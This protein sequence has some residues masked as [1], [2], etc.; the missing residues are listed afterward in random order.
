VILTRVQH[1]YGRPSL[2]R[3][4][5]SLPIGAEV[6]VDGPAENPNPWRGYR[7]CL[8]NL[9]DASH[10][11]VVQDDTVAC[12][13]LDL[14]LPMLAEARPDTLTSLFVGGLPGRNLR[15]FWHTLA[16]GKRWMRLD[17]LRVVHVVALLW[18]TPL[19]R[20]FLEWTETARLP[21]HKGLPRSDDEIV[22]SFVRL[23]KRSVFATVPCLVEHP[24]DVDSTCHRRRADGADKGRCA[25]QW[26]GSEDDPATF[27]WSVA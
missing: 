4:V 23:T 12:R 21:G 14:V 26:V 17:N 15:V 11:L 9:G 7:K 1:L 5:A 13:N 3:T 19:A 10:V 22:G 20:E 16:S 25:I 18:P 2:G 27:D 6:I 8:E 24:D